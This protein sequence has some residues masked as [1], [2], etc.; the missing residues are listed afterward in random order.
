[1][2]V[3]QLT[4]AEQLD[5]FSAPTPNSASRLDGALDAIRQKFGSHAVTRAGNLED[6]S[7]V[8]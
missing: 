1:V 7:S 8:D 5:L 6:K 2:G 3:S 4:L